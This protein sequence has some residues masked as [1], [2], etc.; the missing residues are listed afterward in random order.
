MI[1][2][3]ELK[4]LKTIDGIDFYLFQP[5]WFR[6]YYRKYP[7]YERITVAHFIRMMI[8]YLE[9][10][11]SIYYLAQKQKILGYICVVKNSKRLKC[12]QAGDIV[13]GPIWVNPKERGFGFGCKGI[14]AVLHG[15]GMEYQNA[16]EFIQKNNYASIRTVEKNG[17]QLIGQACFYGP[18]KRVRLCE[19][20]TM[21]VYQYTRQH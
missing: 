13:L 1:Q 6:W 8:E 17:F 3:K 14:S 16:Y 2:T 20:G 18:L 4:Y 19:N 10:G 21:Y 11:Y 5:K 9:S 12:V 15:L 7:E